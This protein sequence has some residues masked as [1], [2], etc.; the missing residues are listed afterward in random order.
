MNITHC[1]LIW[2]AVPAL[3]NSAKQTFHT[4]LDLNPLL[5]FHHALCIVEKAILEFC[6]VRKGVLLRILL[7]KI[8]ILVRVFTISVK[9]IEILVRPIKPLVRLIQI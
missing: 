9:V 6:V 4:I 1:I 3:I 8:N 7:R 5:F 2:I